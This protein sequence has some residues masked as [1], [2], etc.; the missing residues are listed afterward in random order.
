MFLEQVKTQ[1]RTTY[2]T[3][4]KLSIWLKNLMNFVVSNGGTSFCVELHHEKS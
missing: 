1:I 4:T 3:L 2:K